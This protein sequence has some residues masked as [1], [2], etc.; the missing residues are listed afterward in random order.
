[1]SESYD[2]FLS[3]FCSRAAAKPNRIFAK[4]PD[5]EISFGD[6]DS[7]SSALAA[8]LAGRGVNAGDR[9][10]LMMRNSPASLTLMFAIAKMDVFGCR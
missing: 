8:W 9:V 7:M 4:F 3:L 6:L 2:G 1:M 10:A 5:R